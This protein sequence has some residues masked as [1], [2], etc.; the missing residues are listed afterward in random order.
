MMDIKTLIDKFMNGTSSL[1]EEQ[2]LGSYFRTEKHLPKEL[3]PYRK[4]FAYFDGGMTDRDLLRD[5]GG[6]SR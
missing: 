3:K 5:G 6:K 2:M 4:M 1:E